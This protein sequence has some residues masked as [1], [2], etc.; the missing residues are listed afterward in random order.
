MPV[1]AFFQFVFMLLFVRRGQPCEKMWVKAGAL[2]RSAVLLWCSSF[3][4][5]NKSALASDTVPGLSVYELF[6]SGITQDGMKKLHGEIAGWLDYWSARYPSDNLEQVMMNLMVRIT[7]AK[8]GWLA[9]SDEP[10]AFHRAIATA[11]VGG[12]EKYV[13]GKV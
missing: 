8:A 10:F 6:P 11:N 2:R 3:L 7:K 13:E 5:Q 4:V 12:F 9:E 1:G